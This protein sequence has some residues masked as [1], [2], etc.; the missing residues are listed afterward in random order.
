MLTSEM[1][2]YNGRNEFN[3]Q[4]LYRETKHS[5]SARGSQFIGNN[6][7]AAALQSFY[8]SS[9][10]KVLIYNFNIIQVFVGVNSSAH[11]LSDE[12]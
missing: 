6:S 4:S 9:N 8:L 11:G 10:I 7:Q 12:S 5:S 3:S 2:E 1:T